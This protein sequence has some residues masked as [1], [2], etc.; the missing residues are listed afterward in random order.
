MCNLDAAAGTAE[1]RRL[2]AIDK[3][4]Q[5]VHNQKLKGMLHVTPI[6]HGHR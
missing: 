2:R 4:R 6:D 1:L 3:E 5:K